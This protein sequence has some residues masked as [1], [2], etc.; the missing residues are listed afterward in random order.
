VIRKHAVQGEQVVEADLRK[1]Q[2]DVEREGPAD[3]TTRGRGKT[4]PRRRRS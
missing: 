1:E 2:V 3:D 4:P